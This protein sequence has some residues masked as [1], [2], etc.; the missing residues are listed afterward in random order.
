M[1]PPT[2]SATGSS[3]TSTTAPSSGSWPFGSSS[4]WRRSSW[5]RSPTRDWT[6]FHSLGDEVDKTLDE[7]RALARGVY[8]SQL[9]DQ[10]LADALRAAALRLPM[11]AIV[12]PDGIGRYPQEVENA[13]YFC[14]LEAMQNASKHAPD[15]HSVTI[16]LGGGDALVFEVRDD[17][18]GF[19]DSAAQEGAGLTNM[20]DRLAA[21]GGAVEI[22]S[23]LGRGTVVTGKVPLDGDRGVGSPPV[24]SPTPSA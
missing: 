14:C 23:V 9:A 2:A 22:R 17:G 15:A 21:I 3:A 5:G 6:S 13:V 18:G 19:D 10:G 8:P 16:I 12:E 20:R 11:A 24:V 7:I 1:S 4:S